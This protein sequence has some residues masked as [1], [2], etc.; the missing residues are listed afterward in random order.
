MKRKIL[1]LATALALFGTTVGSV[2]AQRVVRAS[3][4]SPAL[5]GTLTLFDWQA[6]SGTKGKALIAAYQH[7][8]P[9]VTIKIL[10]S[11]PGDPTVWEQSVLAAHAAPD[12]LVPPY[13]QSVFSDL[14]KNYWLD[15]TPYMQTPD[16]YVS[17]NKH[18]IDVFNQTANLQNSFEGSKYYVVS[19]SA[20]DVAFFYNKAI[21]QKAGITHTPTT[22][23]ELMADAALIKK[24]GYYAIQHFL[25][26]QYPIG[27]NGSILSQFENQVMGKTFQRLDTDHNGIVDIKELVYGIKHGIYSPM[28]ADYQ[29]AWKLLQQYSQTWQP[30][31]SGNKGDITGAA[32]VADQLWFSGKVA[33]VYNGNGF[34]YQIASVKPK[35]Q[36]GVFEFPQIT[37]AS[38]AF[39]GNSHKNVGLWGAWNADAFSVPITTKDNGHLAL[40]LD[41]LQYI[42]APDNDI[43][44]VNEDGY[45]PVAST[46]KP[47]DAVQAVFAD[48]L[49]HPTMQF[50]AEATLGPE[51]LKERISTMQSYLLGMESLSQAMSDMQ[52]Y[53]NQAADNLVKIYH[54]SV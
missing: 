54:L 14:P 29:E 46:Y 9:G 35:F 18:W 13:T 40:A 1:L 28:N 49:R 37:S 3:G 15:L 4:H 41:F 12:I 21:F 27:V 33:M 31:A 53:T 10:P 48:L 6:F 2:P 25:G 24:A 45:T 51:W 7:M 5:S 42:T 19:W 8:H 17:G 30:N 52:R 34:L 16:P 50:A 26:E 36:W 44:I 23:A 22:W 20:Q 38:S 43:A 39:A 32:A 11:P 47:A